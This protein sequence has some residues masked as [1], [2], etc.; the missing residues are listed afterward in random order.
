MKKPATPIPSQRA[1]DGR[2]RDAAP[3][4]FPAILSEILAN[5]GE[6]AIPGARIGALAGFTQLGQC[7]VDF[8]ENTC[9]DPVPAR[10]VVAL[11]AGEL[12]KDVVLVFERGDPRKPIVMGVLQ[13]VDKAGARPTVGLGP[14]EAV[15]AEIDGETVKLTARSQIVLRCGEASITLT[16][17]GKVLISGSYVLSRSTGANK[18][19]GG[20]IQLN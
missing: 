18:L 13:S 20:S 15:Q 9:R 3:S 2:P 5:T 4:E 8:P 19:K 6:G 17:A 1:S 11:G 12:G 16:R 7:L 10:S 14:S